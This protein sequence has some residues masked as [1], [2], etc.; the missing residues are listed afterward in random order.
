MKLI[1]PFKGAMRRNSPQAEIG[2]EWISNAGRCLGPDGTSGLQP[3]APNG[4]VKNLREAHPEPWCLSLHT[5]TGHVHLHL[6]NED[7]RR[8]RDTLNRMG[9]EAQVVC[10]SA[11]RADEAPPTAPGARNEVV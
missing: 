4:M 8:L 9:D 7:A 3:D 1:G 6:S 10:S 5:E 2:F 11:I